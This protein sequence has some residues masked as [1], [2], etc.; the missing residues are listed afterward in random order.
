M[1]FATFIVE[2]QPMEWR[3]LPAAIIQWCQ[4]AGIL[5]AFGL[6]LIAVFTRGN[7]GLLYRNDGKRA[8]YWYR[9]IIP[10]L[11]GAAY[12]AVLGLYLARM[13]GVRRIGDKPLEAYIPGPRGSFTMGDVILAAAG[14]FAILFL[15]IPMFRSVLFDFRWGRVWAIAKLG[16]KEQIR[17]RGIFIFGF[18]ALIFLFADWFV[19]YKAEDQIRNYVRVLYFS[20]TPLYILAAAYLGAFSIPN[21]VKTLTIHTVVT[22]PI[23]KFEIVV[24]RFLGYAA[25]LTVGIF[26]IA[27]VSL[28]YIARGVT[29][30]AKAESFTARV[31]VY[32]Q[33]EFHHT[34]GESVGREWDYR[35]YI[36]GMQMSTSGKKQYAGW[37][38]PDLSDVRPRTGEGADKS[39][40]VRIQFT[41]DIFRLT[42]G[43]EGKGVS[44]TF[45][46]TEGRLAID[47]IEKKAEEVRLATE[48]AKAERQKKA[49]GAPI[50]YLAERAE[51][52]AEML[53]KH[54][55]YEDPEIEVIDYQTQ[56][57]DVPYALFEKM[58]ELHKDAK[59]GPD[60]IKPAAM[61]VLVSINRDR[62]SQAQMLGVAKHDL[63]ILADER[64]FEINF[65]KGMIGLWFAT[66]LV[67]AVAIAC[68]TYLSGVISFL[69]TLFLYMA[70]NYSP[71]IVA[72]AEGRNYGGGPLESSMR[73]LSRKPVMAPLDDTPT[74]TMLKLSDDAFRWWLRLFVNVLPDVDRYDL[75][76]Y[77]AHGFDISWTQVLFAD[78]LLGL[79]GYLLPWAVLAF[80]L[81][82][83][84][85]IAN[86]M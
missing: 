63:Y 74:T 37:Q 69:C 43:V 20:L 67:L 11:C 28:L 4:S 56:Y 45:L 29:E 84:R 18:V 14:F 78:N 13:I 65:L 83:N 66:L 61:Q 22:K 6:F 24:G 38:F 81:M 57:L 12:L 62:G 68:S 32:G 25:L 3:F 52:Q 31:P 85:E 73:I 26:A 15:A 82:Q 80:Y 21:D 64:L 48:Q 27:L 40:K 75:H 16:I 55:F 17:N 34:K 30:E 33:L 8:P 36:G 59:P 44:C 41:F 2:R 72:L 53:A 51:I 77:V 1:L 49:G 54:G 19:P 46:F 79:I 9:G 39:G 50:D 10:F 5:A 47:E 71:D 70:G 23:T 58:R 42:K 76:T 86:P 60:Q 35:R 7:L